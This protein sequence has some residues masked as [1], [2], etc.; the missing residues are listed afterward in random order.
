MSP[1]RR[2]VPLIVIATIAAGVAVA[3][4]A[5]PSG[6]YSGK[7][8]DGATVRLS[9]NKAQQ[10]LKVRREGLRF[11]CTDGDK[12]KSLKSTATGTV[13]VADKTFDIGDT[14][15]DDAVTWVMKG[16]FSTKKR[17]V[18]GT[19]SETRVFNS[20]DELDPNGTVTCKTAELTFSAVLPK[21]R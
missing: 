4:A 11:T 9:V 21:K 3:E 12:F 19:Y 13:D 5:V 17:K 14:D 8:S 15:P 10:L 16:R 20:K 1:L 18:K 2:L 6:T 7:F